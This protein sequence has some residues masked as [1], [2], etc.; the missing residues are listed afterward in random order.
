MTLL[1]R[2]GGV[3]GGIFQQLWADLFSTIWKVVIHLVSVFPRNQK[4]LNMSFG[5]TVILLTHY[6]TH[7]ERKFL[8]TDIF[9]IICTNNSQLTL[10]LFE[11]KSALTGYFLCI[12]IHGNFSCKIYEKFSL[13]GRSW[14]QKALWECYLPCTLSNSK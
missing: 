7:N 2:R 8:S 3:A 10:N 1:S 12:W 6:K 11:N 9:L 13:I 14:T 5:P 4:S